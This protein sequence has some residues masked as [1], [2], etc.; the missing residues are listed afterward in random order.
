MLVSA[1]SDI[2]IHQSD[3]LQALRTGQCHHLRFHDDGGD[4][5]EGHPGMV[6]FASLGTVALELEDPGFPGMSSDLTSQE[7][8]DS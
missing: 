6:H 4:D 7:N 1:E 5:K 8:Q 2:Y 3:R